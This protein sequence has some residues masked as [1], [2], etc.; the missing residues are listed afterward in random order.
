MNKHTLKDW[1]LATRP[2]SFTASA[3]PVIVSFVWLIWK[4][5]EVNWLYGI[6]ALINI[7]F[8]HAAGNVWSDYFDYKHKVDAE[9]TYAV[10][11]LTSGQFTPKEVMRLSVILQIIAIALG[12]GLVCLTGL[13]LLWIGICGIALSLLYPPLKY[14][15][16]GDLVIILCYAVL[17]ALGTTYVASGSIVPQVLWIIIPIGFLTVGILHSNNMRD[18]GTDNRAGIKT[19]AMISGQ[20]ASKI[21]YQLETILPYLC[22][23]LIA[24]FAHNRFAPWW[25][26][27]TWVS[28]PIALKNY[29]AAKNWGGDPAEIA[30][31][32]EQS[33]QL[34]M[35][36]S[37][38]T[39]ISL[40]IGIWL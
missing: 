24:I 32:D 23:L 38:L 9:D 28:L 2:W 1:I 14:H 40:V 13:P 3:M 11:I 25:I 36:F 35:I 6:W 21:I 37:I 20:K 27:L 29:K 5:L 31:L 19:F 26:L 10:K 34:Q 15:A 22:Y 17:P 30:T 7:I 33:A 12:L 18:A 4:G 16:L 8:V 39:I